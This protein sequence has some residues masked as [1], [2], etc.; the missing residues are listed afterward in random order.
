MCLACEMDAWWL[1]AIEAAREAKASR[2]TADLT[3]VPFAAA[4]TPD[5]AA[6][7]GEADRVGTGDGDLSIGW[8]FEPAAPAFPPELPIGG[9]EFRNASAPLNLSPAGRGRIAPWR[10]PGEGEPPAELHS[11]EVPSP[12]MAGDAPTPTSPLLGE[13]QGSASSPEDLHKAGRRSPSQPNPFRCEEP[14]SR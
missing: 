14:G 1:P 6:R 7:F 4:S 3:L 11:I 13:V 2:D 5:G 8:L 12:G 10:D 9:A